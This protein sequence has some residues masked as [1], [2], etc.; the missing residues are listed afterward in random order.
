MKI[1][2]LVWVGL[3]TIAIGSA[4]FL[5]KHFAD[6]IEKSNQKEIDTWVEESLAQALSKKLNRPVQETL[7]ALRHPTIY[8]SELNREI[9][10]VVQSVQ[11]IFSKESSS[12]YTVKLYLLYK[13]ASTF[14]TIIDKSWDSL[15]AIVRKHFL[16]TGS[17]TVRIPWE[18]PVI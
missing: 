8:N 3:T 13:D 11:L 14:S 4:A 1:D 15:P 18:F 9:R 5:L 2:T 12:E 16:Q 10:Q 17:R 7:A 6:R